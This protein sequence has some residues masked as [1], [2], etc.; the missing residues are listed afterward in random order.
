MQG[1]KGQPIQN[2]SLPNWQKT[3]SSLKIN[4]TSDPIIIPWH[5]LFWHPIYHWYSQLFQKPEAKIL[6]Y[7]GGSH[8]AC[9]FSTACLKILTLLLLQ[10]VTLC[11]NYIWPFNSRTHHLFH[12]LKPTSLCHSLFLPQTFIGCCVDMGYILEW[13]AGDILDVL[14]LL[15]LKI[16]RSNQIGPWAR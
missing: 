11:I 6:A 5:A 4:W 9:F 2:L 16:V 14:D 10:S 13:D 8:F 12:K 3:I 1:K 15:Y 7:F